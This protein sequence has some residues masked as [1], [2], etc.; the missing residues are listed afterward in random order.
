[1]YWIPVADVLESEGV[2]VVLVD[3]REVRMVPGIQYTLVLS[4]ATD[5]TRRSL[6]QPS[7]LRSSGVVVPK[8]AMSCPPS[9]RRGPQT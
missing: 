9:S 3:T 5:S 2:E 7:S 4:I 8:W 1:M 6:S